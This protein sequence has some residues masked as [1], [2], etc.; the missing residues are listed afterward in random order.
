VGHSHAHSHGHAGHNHAHAGSKR[1]LRIA[2]AFTVAFGVIELVCG[3]LFGS[4]ALISDALHNV[5]DGLAIGLALLAAWAAG[6][7]A[8]GARTFGWRRAEVLAALVNG[9]ALIAISLVVVGDAIVR[10]TGTQPTVD[11]WAVAIVGAVGV[12]ANGIPVVVM[13]R[14]G[15][16]TNINLRGALLH[17]A[18]DLLGSFGAVLAGLAVALFGWDWADPVMAIL[19]GVL[20]GLTSWTLIR[21]SLRVLMEVAPR[22]IDVEEIGMGLACL[23]GVKQVHDLH[24]WEITSGM[25]AVA[26]H[27]VT[28]DGAD[29]DDVLHAAQEF[30]TGHGIDHATVQVDRDHDRLLQIQPRGRRTAG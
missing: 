23:P 24:V 28:V 18:S 14:D 3:Y 2:L 19:I 22:G 16:T 15:D 20:V 21:D 8:R 17:A 10:L 4:L 6:L 11:G 25:V 30:L 12:I 7:P 29:Q 9:I 13:L 5:S 27:V 26:V 1:A